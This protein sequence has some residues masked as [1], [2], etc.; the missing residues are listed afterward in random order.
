MWRP[1]SVAVTRMKQCR[2]MVVIQA[3]HTSRAHRQAGAHLG[4]CRILEDPNHLA[5]DLEPMPS[6]PGGA[7]EIN[8]SRSLSDVKCGSKETSNILTRK[9]WRMKMFFNSNKSS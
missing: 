8:G 9:A 7:L 6:R 1:A 3:Q 4:V 5:P 2:L